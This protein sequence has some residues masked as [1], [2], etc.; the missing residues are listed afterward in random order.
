MTLS[1]YIGFESPDEQDARM[2][3]LRRA[4]RPLVDNGVLPQPLSFPLKT[5]RGFVHGRLFSIP[6]RG[7]RAEKISDA[8]RPVLLLLHRVREPIARVFICHASAD[9][10]VARR[11][12]SFL[13]L[14][15]VE[16]WVDELKIKVGD[17]IVARISE[18]VGSATH[19][20]L[21]V[22]AA[23]AARPWVAKEFSVALMRQL[24]DA[25]V[26]VMPVRLDDTPPPPIL[27]DVRYADCRRDIWAGF[28][29]I[30][31]SITIST[32]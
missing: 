17:S 22:S 13:E 32:S 27:A 6:G 28:E 4:Y 20:A 7:R 9:K 25:S 8:I 21:L 16:V 11:L 24:A 10:P 18:G 5:N 15:G 19:V 12:A 14:R 3:R 1:C 31:E 29:Q 2:A 26:R 23:S 30:F